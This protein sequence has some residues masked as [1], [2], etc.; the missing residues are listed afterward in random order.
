MSEFH[1]L[2]G[3]WL[4]AV[5]PALL[6]VWRLWSHEDAG[7]AWRTLIAPHLLPHLLTGRDERGWIRPVTV[8]PIVWMLGVMALAGPTW[9]REPAQSRRIGPCS[10][11][12]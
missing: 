4:L 10:P 1:F 5:I 8:L 6:V 9:E 12:F 3:W 2:R 7:R 11:S